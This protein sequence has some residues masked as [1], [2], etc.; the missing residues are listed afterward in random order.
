MQGRCHFLFF[1]TSSDQLSVFLCLL[2][3]P[4][5]SNCNLERGQNVSLWRLL[6]HDRPWCRTSDGQHIQHLM[7]DVHTLEVGICASLLD[8]RPGLGAVAVEAGDVGRCAP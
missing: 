1:R 5:R 4:R 6:D 8:L 2:L 3:V 7:F